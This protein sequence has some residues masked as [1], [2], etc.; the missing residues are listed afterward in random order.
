MAVDFFES[1][2][3]ARRNTS[4]LVVLFGLAIVAITAAIYALAVYVSAYLNAGMESSNRSGAMAPIALQW[5]DSELMV[6]VAIGV[7]IVVAGGSLYK[8][9]QL[10]SGGKAVAE[11]LGGRLLHADA[12]DRHERVL[13]N[14]V[15]EMAIASG[16]PTPPVYLLPDEGGINAFAAGFS[17]ND[18]VIGVTRG[19]ITQL[20]RDE[21]QGVIAHEFSHI[22]NGDM[23]LNIRLMGVLHGILIIGIIGYFMMRSAAFSSV[24]RR[25]NRDNSGML[26][27]GIGFGL[28]AIGSLGTF[29]GNWI[30][31]SVSRQREFLADASAVQ[32]TRNPMGI[33]GAL[34]QIGGF[35]RGSKI[36]NPNAPEASHLFFGQALRGGFQSIFAT[37]PPLSE[38]IRRLDPSFQD[39]FPSVSSDAHAG[40]AAP[41]AASELSM[42][43]A[44]G[45]DRSVSVENAIRDIGRPT[46][47]HLA[48]AKALIGSLPET[49]TQAAHESYGARALIYALLLDRDPNPRATQLERLAQFGEPGIDALTQSLFPLAANIEPRARLPLID[50]ALPALRDLSVAQYEAFRDNVEILVRADDQIDLFEWTLQRIL[51]AHLRPHFERVRPP[52]IK[53]SAM[54]RLSMP[55]SLLFSALAHSWVKGDHQDAFQR[56]AI[57]LGLPGLR[58]LPPERCGLQSLDQALSQLAQATPTLKRRILQACVEYIAADGY[59]TLDEAELLRA[60][61]DTLDCPMPPLLPGQPVA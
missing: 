35:E 39:E 44:G 19:A 49:I 41:S 10:R 52:S 26:F 55:C 60:T 47:E 17:P 7:L 3:T 4:R 46:P 43:I 18:A 25:S 11:Q 45:E 12:T 31:A 51:L 50:M 58:V 33:A 48:Y 56:A 15:E 32:F 24:R 1:Q 42:G 23:R 21:L 8:I 40:G 28:V 13:L 30:K 14:I 16:T 53:Y 22:L 29:F 9:S 57:T 20:D 61:A 38:R 34:K 54:D 36:A 2:D 59:V 27:L 37:H 5:W 6:G